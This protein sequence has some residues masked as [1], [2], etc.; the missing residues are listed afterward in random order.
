MAFG[1]CDGGGRRTAPRQAAPLIAII[2][3]LKDTHEARLVDVSTTGVRLKGED[4]P[5]E[6]EELFL[7]IE[8][9]RTFGCVAWRRDGECGIAFEGP[10]PPDAVNGLRQKAAKMGGQPPELRAAFEDWTLGLA[11]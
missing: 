7:T 2:T 4:L 5:V 11:R 9:V 1:K 6:G 8:S 3:T 10:L